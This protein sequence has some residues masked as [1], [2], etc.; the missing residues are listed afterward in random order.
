MEVCPEAVST[1]W[2]YYLLILVFVTKLWRVQIMSS[3]NA[4]FVKN[5][6]FKK[7]FLPSRELVKNYPNNP[8]MK[9]TFD[10]AHTF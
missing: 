1:Q 10:K 9:N 6:I 3:K 7:P 4:T 8:G 5:S 2:M